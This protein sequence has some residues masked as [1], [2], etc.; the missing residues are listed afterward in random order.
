MLVDWMRRRLPH[1][2][3]ALR[4]NAGHRVSRAIEAR[5]ELAASETLGQTCPVIL[6]EFRWCN[7]RYI[8]LPATIG[9]FYAPRINGRLDREPGNICHHTIADKRADANRTVI[10]A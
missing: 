1:S 3:D 6:R 7:I 2:V 5:L 10:C 8:A 4:R 9:Y